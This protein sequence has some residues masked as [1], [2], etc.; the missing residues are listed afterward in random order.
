TRSWRRTWSPMWSMNA[1]FTDVTWA[2]ST[3]A[4]A[5]TISAWSR[6]P[7]TA[8]GGAGRKH[9]PGMTARPRPKGGHA[10]KA[11]RARND[12]KLFANRRAIE[13]P[14]V[15]ARTAK[16]RSRRASARTNDDNRKEFTGRYAHGNVVGSL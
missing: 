9:A 8:A 10:R 15:T 6:P 7:S 1:A 13:P 4:T 3:P 2:S 12:R 14:T 11:A 16:F 5:P